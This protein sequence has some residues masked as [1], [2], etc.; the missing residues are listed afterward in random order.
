MPSEFLVEALDEELADQ[1]LATRDLP[2]GTLNHLYPKVCQMLAF[3]EPLENFNPA[4]PRT[5]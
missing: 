2:T 3:Q 4:W 5:S 1:P